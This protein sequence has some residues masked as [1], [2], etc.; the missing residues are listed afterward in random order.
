MELSLRIYN[1]NSDL[2]SDLLWFMFIMNCEWFVLDSVIQA[3][4]EEVKGKREE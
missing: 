3:G 2:Q 1:K 4:I